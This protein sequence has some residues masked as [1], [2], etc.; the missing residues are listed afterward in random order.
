MSKLLE[1]TL[2]KDIPTFE[3]Y[4]AHPEGEVRNKTTKRLFTAECKKHR[5][6]S[7][8]LNSKTI[9]KH[10]LIALTFH[11]NPNN[12]EQVN[13]KDGNKKNN[14]ANNLEWISQSDNIKDSVKRGRKKLLK[15]AK[16]TAIKI[17]HKNGDTK[18]YWS[19]TEAQKELKV[20]C[21]S[22]LLKKDGFYYKTSTLDKNTDNWLWKVERIINSINKNIIEKDITIEGFTH[23]IACFD[24]RVLNKKKRT[25][26]GSSQDSRYFR[27]QGT[28]KISYSIHRL[29]AETFIP[30]PENKKVVNHIDGNTHNNSVTNLEWVTQSENMQHAIKTKLI[31]SD[32]EKIR[33]DKMKCP[34]YQLELDGSIIKEWDGACD[35]EELTKM[36]SSIISSICMSYK[37]NVN[38]S[39]NSHFGYGWCYVS[40]YKESKPNISFTSLFPTITDLK[41]INFNILRKYVIRGS[42]PV[43]QIDLD[44]TRVKFWE[45]SKDAID[46]GIG[47]NVSNIH[48]SYSSGITLSGGYFW[49]LA[50]YE[51]IIKPTRHYIKIIPNIIKKAL[52]LDNDKV[53]IKSGI[54]TLLRENISD[55]GGFRVKVR[56]IAQLNLDG[57]LIK[58]WPGPTFAQKQ[59]GYGR[60]VIEAVLSGKT[61]KTHGYKWR[62]LT[63]DEIVENVL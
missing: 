21:I 16:A 36:N 18:Q 47:G 14:K 46:N 9:A 25:E 4:E 41:N 10:R 35:T 61:T 13:H 39:C 2:W 34:I 1:E 3:N 7:L 58:Y 5:Y 62:Y 31:N 23:L 45:C 22:Y 20:S 11:D 48:K 63:L 59:L 28:N 49:Q 38:N 40:D 56:P 33:S 53:N 55:D 51:D 17:T 26:V 37:K 15:H 54:L 60:N 8:A 30:N 19:I 29:I 6:I 24:G 50:S 42:R 52:K 32:T 43:W 44:G 12:L 27:I 57:T